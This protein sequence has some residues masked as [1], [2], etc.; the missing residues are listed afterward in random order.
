MGRWIMGIIDDV[1]AGDTTMNNAI[2][3]N[4]AGYDGVTNGGSM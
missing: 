3:G 4:V 2:V 1:T